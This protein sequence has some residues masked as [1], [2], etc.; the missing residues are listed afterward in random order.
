MKD[1]ARWDWLHSLF[2][3]KNDKRRVSLTYRN[4]A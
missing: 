1:E 3:T 2:L 4:L